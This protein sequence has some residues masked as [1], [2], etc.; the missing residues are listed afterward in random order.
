MFNR[1]LLERYL[2]E[3]LQLY[4]GE[5]HRSH[6]IQEKEYQA[7]QRKVELYNKRNISLVKVYG[8]LDVNN[9]WN[10]QDVIYINYTFHTR[11]FLKQTDL[12]FEEDQ[13][14]RQIAIEND[15]ILYDIAFPID[16][17]VEKFELE[18]D[19]LGESESLDRNNRYN[20]F[21]AV[22]YAETWWDGHNKEYPLY[23]NDCTNFISQCLR[24]GGVRMVGMPKPGTGWWYKNHS[25][26]SY[27]WRVAHALR[28][29][30][31]SP[32]T[33]IKAEEVPSPNHLTLGDIIVY[34]FEGDGVWNHCTIV[35]AKDEN[36]EPLV[37]A[38]TVNSRKRY[39]SY[40]DSSAFTENIKYKFFHIVDGFSNPPME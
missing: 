16:N 24:A 13:H 9:I 29:F 31:P 6:L 33:G 26:S 35:V 23:A 37:N 38:H 4:F 2:K 28:R 12:Y 40:Y 27:S 39:W 8:N 14:E 18:E 11:Y 20:R 22:K 15:E 36:G 1:E 25:N 30:L 19:D 3:R 10:E 17:Q 32:K 5:G 34:D 21:N 7:I